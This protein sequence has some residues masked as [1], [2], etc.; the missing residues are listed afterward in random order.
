[1][2]DNWRSLEGGGKDRSR[3]EKARYVEAVNNDKVSVLSL[4]K[5]GKGP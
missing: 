3:V 5:I 2:G 1:M 4:M